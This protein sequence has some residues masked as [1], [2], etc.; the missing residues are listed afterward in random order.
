ML[1]ELKA[2]L[3]AGVL[4]QEEFDE[5]KKTILKLSLKMTNQL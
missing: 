5:Q 2:V 3:D 1:L 4:T